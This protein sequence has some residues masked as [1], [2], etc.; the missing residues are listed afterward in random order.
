MRKGRET[1]KR[2]KDRKENR[3]GEERK[4]RKEK[5]DGE[6]SGKGRKG[7]ERS[8]DCQCQRF[9]IDVFF[10][11]SVRYIEATREQA[12]KGSKGDE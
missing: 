7:E 6:W 12:G 2:G 9:I 11:E 5:E 8:L 3:K 4:K 1:E 10:H